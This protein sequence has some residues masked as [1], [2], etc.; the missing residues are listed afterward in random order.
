MSKIKNKKEILQI[1][2][3]NFLTPRIISLEKNEIAM[4]GDIL[5]CETYINQINSNLT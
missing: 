3:D 4:R 5:L 1:L 2:F